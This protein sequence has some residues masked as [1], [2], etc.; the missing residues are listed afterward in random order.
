M[1]VS[2]VEW[3]CFFIAVVQHGSSLLRTYTFR[4]RRIFFGT[5]LWP[6]QGGVL[7]LR[8]C[9]PREPRSTRS[10][11]AFRNAN[12]LA[13]AMRAKFALDIQ[14]GG[15]VPPAYPCVDHKELW[16]AAIPRSQPVGNGR[17]RNPAMV[18]GPGS[19]SRSN[20]I[21]LRRSDA[22][23]ADEVHVRDGKTYATITDDRPDQPSRR[24]HV[25][26]GAKIETPNNKLKWTEAIQ[27]ATASCS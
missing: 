19:A 9:G 8:T 1:R 20:C 2:S 23:R 5:R 10:R 25:D 4:T 24:P 27:Q 13:T 21:M 17:S 12:L 14:A 7:R 22:Y 15:L 3:L 16:R 18:P 11:S 6:V 26:V